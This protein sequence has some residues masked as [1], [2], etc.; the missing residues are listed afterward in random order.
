MSI[1]FNHFK[2]LRHDTSFKIGH[3]NHIYD[4]RATVNFLQE[5]TNQLIPIEVIYIGSQQGSYTLVMFLFLLLYLVC[6]AQISTSLTD[7][8]LIFLIYQVFT[9]LEFIF[10]LKESLVGIMHIVKSHQ[11]VNIKHFCL[12]VLI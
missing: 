9:L 4:D 6:E 11:S 1:S 8:Q 3:V 7:Q 2:N 10:V 5:G 12:Y